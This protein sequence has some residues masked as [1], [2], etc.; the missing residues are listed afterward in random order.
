MK[1][2]TGMALLMLVA[3]LMS[4][5]ILGTTYIL[6]TSRGIGEA[7]LLLKLKADYNIESSFLIQMSKL[8]SQAPSF[9]DPETAL[10]LPRHE[11]AP[12]I[13]LS[14]D[15]S[16]IGTNTFRLTSRIEGGGLNNR[17]GA[18]LT[19]IPTPTSADIDQK[20]TGETGTASVAIQA[21]QWSL[22]YLPPS[23]NEP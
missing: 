7:P 21:S 5:L 10:T 12:G 1:A 4:M 8:R 3:I 16:C 11:I 9:P 15:G 6:G 18:V 22:K 13:T 17:L 23:V 14:A 20:H 19:Y 2:R